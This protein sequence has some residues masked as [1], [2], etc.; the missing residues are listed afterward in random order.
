MFQLRAAAEAMKTT[1]TEVLD[2]ALCQILAAIGATGLTDYR[3]KCQG[4]WRHT[5]LSHT[6]F[7]FLEKYPF[8][9]NQD[10]ILKKHQLVKPF[11]LWIPT[12]QDW[13]KPDKII[14][15]NVDLWFTDESG[16]HDL[17]CAGIYGFSHNY[18]EAYVWAADPSGR[19]V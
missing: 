2:V 4:E 9:L 10:R 11:K 8:R 16:I 3:L 6:K 19:A 17:F 1:P 13:K 15:P 7:N 5:G 12:R 18:R 14:D